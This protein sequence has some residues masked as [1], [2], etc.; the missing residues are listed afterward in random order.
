VPGLGGRSAAIAG[1]AN[2]EAVAAGPASVLFRVT[3]VRV[4]AVALKV[5]RLD[6]PPQAQAYPRTWMPADWRIWA[7]LGHP[8]AM[9]VCDYGET[10]ETLYVATK[11]VDG[12]SLRDVLDRRGALDAL[13]I[14]RLAEQL[15]SVLDAAATARLLHLDVKPENVLFAGGSVEHAFLRDFG[16]GQLAAWRSGVDRSRTF[17]G[18]LEY[19]APEQL[20][21]GMADRRTMVYSLGCLLYEALAGATP[22]AGRSAEAQL[23]AH[24]EEGP[25]PVAGAPDEVNLVFAKALAK[26]RNERF[27]TCAEFAEALCETLAF[28]PAPRALREAPR[29]R[30]LGVRHVAIAASLAALAAA[31]TAGAMVMSGGSDA[32]DPGAE[33]AVPSLEFANAVEKVGPV[34]KA[35]RT[36][37][38]A[39]PKRTARVVRVQKPKPKRHTVARKARP[40]IHKPATQAPVVASTPTPRAT[41]TVA[42]R[43]S[44]VT[45]P[46]PRTT[47]TV[48]AAPQETPLPPPPPT[49]PA[50]PPTPPPPP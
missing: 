10:N 5:F 26:R 48:A 40:V 11:W 33:H 47:T 15:A 35:A 3:R 41:T 19:V 50:L 4:G 23:S 32:A 18:P 14:R 27:A 13:E 29:R 43:R 46:P 37:L 17:R 31:A 38:R 8:H 34:V 12:L 44:P 6:G 7:E 16:A 39:A 28:A 25:P 42:P 45:T 20:K 1:Y 36:P 22:Y 2:A 9:P 24:L 30:P 49:D 21:G